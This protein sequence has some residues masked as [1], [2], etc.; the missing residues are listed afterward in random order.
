MSLFQTAKP[1]SAAKD[2][3]PASEKLTEL[4]VN[5]LDHISQMVGATLGPGGRQ[6]L[7]E[8]Q[9]MNMKPVITKDGVTVIKSLGYHHSIQQLILES[10]R[11]AA[12]RTASE[13]GDGTTTATILSASIVRQ[14]NNY[15]KNRCK[16]SPQSIVREMQKLVPNI[17]NQITRYKLQINSDNYSQVLERVATL[18]ANGDVELA[19]A[20]MEAFDIVGEEGNLTIIEAQGESKYHIERINGYTVERGYE[21]SCRNFANGFIND[22]TGTMVCLTNP[23]FL[24]FD[25]TIN[26]LSQVLNAFQKMGQAFETN[27]RHDRGIVIVAHG[28]SDAFIA[29]LHL[30]WNHPHSTAKVF[31]LL[32]PQNAIK[33][34]GSDFLRDLQAYTGSPVFNPLDNPINDLDPETIISMNRVTYFECSRFRSSVIAEE[35]QL[36]IQERVD[37]LKSRVCESEYEKNDINVRIGKLTSGIARLTIFAPSYGESREKRDRAE[38]AWMAIRGAVKYGACPGG[39][40]VLVRLSSELE[41]KAQNLPISSQRLA[42]EILAVALR[43]PVITLYKNYGYSDKEIETFMY[44]LLMNDDQTYNIAEQM[45]VDKYDMLDSVPAVVEAIRNSISIASLLGTLGGIIA[46]KRDTEEDRKEADFVRRFEAASG[47]RSSVN[48]LSE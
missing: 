45:W 14:I 18:S 23:I 28:F 7:L 48:Q 33:N 3:V 8:R 32:T 29:D 43:E 46:F 41:V 31:P 11:D 30:N 9:E 5:T 34:S 42:H 22:K 27:H 44:N 36:A 12:M 47:I 15:T 2:M 35:D 26:D 39:G 37:E 21:E 19:K 25:G 16:Y 17:I 38:D 24:L 10:A 4:V 1:K 13:A 40:W 6:V 20:I